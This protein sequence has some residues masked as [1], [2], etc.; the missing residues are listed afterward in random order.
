MFTAVF[1]SDRL[2]QER[3]RISW[4]LK[5]LMLLLLLMTLAVAMLLY[6]YSLRQQRMQRFD[7]EIAEAARRHGISFSLVKAVIMQ[8]S[9]FDPLAT[10]GAGEIGLMQLMSGAVQDWQRHHRREV[11]HPG[12]LYNPRLNVEIGTWYLA[13]ALR[14]WHEYRDA[15]VLALAQY[16]AGGS[17]AKAWAP[18]DPRENALSR[19][20]FPGTRQYIINVLKYRTMFEQDYHER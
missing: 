8:E 9:R 17:R 1:G 15:E 14:T 7:A 20:S 18:P 13:R 4:Q 2:S 11:A 5:L 10:G 19:V 12:L 16:N 3:S 6:R